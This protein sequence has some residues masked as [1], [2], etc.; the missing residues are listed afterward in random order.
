MADVPQSS[1][2]V[3]LVQW[4]VFGQNS[5]Q[6]QHRVERFGHP[7]PRLAESR[8]HLSVDGLDRDWTGQ[9]LDAFPGRTAVDDGADSPQ[10]RPDSAALQATF[11]R[12]VTLAL[13]LGGT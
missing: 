5:R 12:V 6:G 3:V 1:R 7:M 2:E 4:G 13:R 10:G 11:A 8:G 9:S